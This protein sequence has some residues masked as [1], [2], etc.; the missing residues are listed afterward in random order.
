VTSPI[1]MRPALC[2]VAINLFVEAS[3]WAEKRIS[4]FSPL[5]DA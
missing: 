1:A 2:E 3:D 4:L 5:L